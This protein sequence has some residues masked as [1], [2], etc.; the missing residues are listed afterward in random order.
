MPGREYINLLTLCWNGVG[1]VVD[2]ENGGDGEQTFQAEVVMPLIHESL[3][4]V[5]V[6]EKE[7]KKRKQ[8]VGV[9]V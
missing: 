7:L 6:A 2:R 4:A 5:R 1:E 3:E 9:A 8:H